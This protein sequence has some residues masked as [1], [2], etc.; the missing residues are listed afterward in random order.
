M[1]VRAYLD[2]SGIQADA[3]VTTV[4]AY[5]STAEKWK[6]FT[7]KWLHVLA[8]FGLSSFH[9]SEYAQR[10]GGFEGWSRE[11]QKKLAERLFPLIPAHTKLGVSVAM[12]RADFDEVFEAYPAI[13]EALGKPY[14]CCFQ[15]LVHLVIAKATF[16]SPKW[17]LA[18]VHEDNDFKREA[19]EA[20]D[21]LKNEKDVAGRLDS[22]TFAPKSSFVP[23]QAAD[24]LAWESQKRLADPT[25]LERKSLTALRKGDKLTIQTMNRQWLRDNAA[26]LD[27]EAH[28]YLDRGHDGQG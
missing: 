12:V 26:R 21:W 6:I 25:R 7:R 11:R 16:A 9:M 5:F 24:V 17:R 28:K 19:M 4:A 18:C 2:E 10:H 15:W 8:D 23:L 20:W 22:L 3:P 27:A 1:I 13:K 14:P